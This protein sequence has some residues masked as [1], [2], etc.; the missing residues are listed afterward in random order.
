MKNKRLKTEILYQQE[1]ERKYTFQP[2]RT[3]KQK[4]SLFNL[5]RETSG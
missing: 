1:E 2:I 4:D 3:A 5:Q